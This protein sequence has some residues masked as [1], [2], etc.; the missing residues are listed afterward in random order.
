MELGVEA[1][2]IGDGHAML[3]AVSGEL[4]LSTCDQL[5]P[6][7]DEAVFGQRPL[8]LDLSGCKFI[9]SSGLRLVL[10]IANGLAE[11]EVP[12]AVIAAESNVR[13]MFSLTAID[14]TIPL[15]DTRQQALLWL[16]GEG[17]IG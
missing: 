3:I 4:D 16:Q 17:K 2:P 15:F 8:I 7:A 1:T 13:K 12:M 6:A 9:D 11:D 10:Q 5:K 14:Q